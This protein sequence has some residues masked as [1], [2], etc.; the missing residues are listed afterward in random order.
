MNHNT[1]EDC[2]KAAWQAIL[3]GDYAERDRLCERAKILLEA[4]NNAYKVER[5]LSVDFYVSNIGECI[6]I[7]IMTK[8][9]N[10]IQ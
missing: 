10:V 7:K 8:A 9:A 2:M 1:T 4:E 6:P 3:K 5:A